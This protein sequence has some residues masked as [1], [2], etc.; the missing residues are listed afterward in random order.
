M[1]VCYICLGL[2]KNPREDVIFTPKGE[3]PWSKT[4][5]REEQVSGHVN[6]EKGISTH[7]G[8]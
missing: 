5:R 3:I 1:D 7:L 4:S 6:P 8:V 2:L